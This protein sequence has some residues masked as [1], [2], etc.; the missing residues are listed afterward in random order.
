MG[1]IFTLCY[2]Q[3]CVI[4]NSVMKRFVCMCLYLLIWWVFFCLFF[5]SG[6]MDTYLKESVLSKSDWQPYYWLLFYPLCNKYCV[7]PWIFT[8]NTYWF[9]KAHCRMQSWRK[10]SWQHHELNMTRHHKVITTLRINLSNNT[11]FSSMQYKSDHKTFI[12]H[13][14]IIWTL[15]HPQNPYH[16]ILSD[17]KRFII[18][19]TS[20]LTLSYKLS[21]LLPSDFTNTQLS[22][23]ELEHMVILIISM[24]VFYINFTTFW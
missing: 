10:S 13:A 15:S 18:P 12:I 20:H 16:T 3:N 21:I 24:Q 2:I 22:D 7:L 6:R 14:C 4:M 9:W 8:V 11:N 23:F 17:L 1:S 5:F 19:L